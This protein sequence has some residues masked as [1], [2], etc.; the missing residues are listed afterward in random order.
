MIIIIIIQADTSVRL[1]YNL[2]LFARK[3]E[4]GGELDGVIEKS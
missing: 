1:S 4:E 3:F 2:A